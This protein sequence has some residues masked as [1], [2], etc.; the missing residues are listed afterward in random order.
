M[1]KKTFISSVALGIASIAISASPAVAQSNKMEKCYGIVKAGQ[2]DCAS[3]NG[4]HSCAGSAKKDADTNEWI[5][6]P[7]GTCKR[8]SGGILS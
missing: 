6:L 8:I 3:K 5:Y 4:T 7:K 1:N 2:N